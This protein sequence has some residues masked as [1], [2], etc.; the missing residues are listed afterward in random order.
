MSRL[1]G[2][3]L[4]AH[5]RA[6]ISIPYTESLRLAAARPERTT[7]VLVGVVDH[8]EGGGARGWREAGDFLALWR[9]MYALLGGG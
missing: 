6:D 2:R 9:V 8:V 5:G 4:I 7:L 1:C 3:A